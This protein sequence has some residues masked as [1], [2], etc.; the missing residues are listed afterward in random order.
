MGSP[1]YIGSGERKA[2][3]PVFEVG[4][5]D[6][7]EVQLCNNQPDWTLRYG[8]FQMPGTENGFTADDRILKWPGKG[9][10]GD[11]WV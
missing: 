11:F 9:S 5:V 2:L 10:G 7:I 3:L 8:F 1:A 4:R 6:F